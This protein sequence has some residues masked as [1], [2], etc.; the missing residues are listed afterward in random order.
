MGLLEKIPSLFTESKQVYEVIQ[1]VFYQML[2]D[3][4]MSEVSPSRGH[5]TS[6]ITHL[7]SL[8]QMPGTWLM[9]YVYLLFHFI[10]QPHFLGEETEL[11]M[12]SNLFK[13]MLISAKFRFE[14]KSMFEPL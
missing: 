6:K 14:P 4:S 10:K 12:S 2:P 8:F 1:Y 7:L 5:E 11:D 13:A 3:Y 9:V